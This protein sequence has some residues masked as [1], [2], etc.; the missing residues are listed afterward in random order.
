ML[1]LGGGE[2]LER[3]GECGGRIGGQGRGGN[4]KEDAG[5]GGCG[6]SWA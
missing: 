3:V 5:G 4:W 2:G 6:I 1:R